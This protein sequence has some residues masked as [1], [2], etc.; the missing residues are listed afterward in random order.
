MAQK[1]FK[2]KD[3]IT[4]TRPLELINSDICGPMQSA[5]I[6]ASKYFVS[7]IDNYSSCS[8]T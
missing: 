8:Y 6:G 7:F 4:S 2:A 5:S 1:Y 3:A